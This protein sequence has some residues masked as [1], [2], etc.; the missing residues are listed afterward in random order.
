[1]ERAGKRKPGG[2]I[3]VAIRAAISGADG[4]GDT[5]TFGNAQRERFETFLELPNGIPPR[6]I[7][8]GASDG[9]KLG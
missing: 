3:A 7:H 6:A 8:S 2:I 4:W 5:E 1:M 9:R